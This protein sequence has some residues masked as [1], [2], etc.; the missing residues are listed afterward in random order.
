MPFRKLVEH[1]CS[2]QA[3]NRPSI[4]QVIDRLAVLKQSD[5]P[6][7]TTVVEDEKTD[8]KHQIF[9]AD[10]DTDLVFFLLK[11]EEGKLLFFFLEARR[12]ET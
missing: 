9:V 6:V 8:Y 2:Y 1:C 7:Y 10:S 12:R 4:D 5:V 11:K 3:S